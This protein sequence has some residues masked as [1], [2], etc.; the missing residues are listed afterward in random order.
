[1]ILEFYFKNTTNNGKPIDY[2]VPS[3]GII[4]YKLK[5]KFSKK[6]KFNY[7][8]AQNRTDVTVGNFKYWYENE[9]NSRGSKIRYYRNNR[10]DRNFVRNARNQKYP[11]NNYCN[12]RRC[13]YY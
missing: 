1:M 6:I 12:R 13:N 3:M 5:K 11:R 10:Y 9:S 2:L 7:N 8:R 4:I